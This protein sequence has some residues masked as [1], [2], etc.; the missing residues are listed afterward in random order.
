MNEAYIREHCLEE[1]M[2]FRAWQ[3]GEVMRM[4]EK[5]VHGIAPDMEV[6]VAAGRELPTV[7]FVDFRL[8]DDADVY[9]Q[10]M[11]YCNSVIDYHNMLRNNIQRVP[12]GKGVSDVCHAA[13]SH[14]CPMW[15]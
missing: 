4:F 2:T 12:R 14:L 1:F 9:H 11:L 6:W 13:R 7:R 5:W 8:F 15:S 10:P 3:I